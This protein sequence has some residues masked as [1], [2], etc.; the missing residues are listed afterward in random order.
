MWD[1]S[2]MVARA[3]TVGILAYGSLI[4]DPGDELAPLISRTVH[5]VVT[6]FPVEF[7]RMSSSRGGAPTLVPH[8]GGARVPGAILVVEASAEHATDVLWRRETRKTDKTLR[9]PGARPNH[10]N[11]VRVHRI[12]DL[13]GIDLVLY[14]AIGANVAPLTAQRLAEL[15]V[16]SVTKAKHGLDGISYLL[17]AKSNGISTPLSPAYEAEILRMTAAGNLESALRLLRESTG[18]LRAPPS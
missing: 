12:D 15:A 6:P 10:P 18:A 13:D 11:A 2:E 7:A 3:S 16:A 8:E 9:Y 17:M 5:D 1:V 4:D 14:T